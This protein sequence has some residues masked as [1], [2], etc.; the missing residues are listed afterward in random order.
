[1]GRDI[2]DLI[3]RKGIGHIGWWRT[4]ND[5]GLDMRIVLV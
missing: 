3:M 4:I 2:F 1:M 5:D